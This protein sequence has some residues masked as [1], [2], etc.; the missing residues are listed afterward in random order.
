M[1]SEDTDTDTPPGQRSLQ[2]YRR[3][4][5][6]TKINVLPGVENN[7]K[8]KLKLKEVYRP[9]RRPRR[10]A[11]PWWSDMAPVYDHATYSVNSIGLCLI[12]RAG[13]T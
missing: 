12:F 6:V 5:M 13:K 10:Y 7:D 3:L 9:Q 8:T 2:R 1:K 4:A 11:R